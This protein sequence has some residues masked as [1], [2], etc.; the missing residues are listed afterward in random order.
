MSRYVTGPLKDFLR[1]VKE[2]HE[3]AGVKASEPYSEV[4]H[5]YCTSFCNHGH[6]LSD[7]KPINHECYII[8]P[9]ALEAEREGDYEL[10]AKLM[11]GKRIV[12]PGLKRKP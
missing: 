7:G 3:K 2:A 8:N 5:I 11:G 12:H 10:A 6:R 1:Q 9:K 4:E